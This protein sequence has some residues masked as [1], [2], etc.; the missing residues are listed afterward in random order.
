MSTLLFIQDWYDIF[1]V[2]VQ[3]S[4]IM[5]FISCIDVGKIL[6]SNNEAGVHTPITSSQGLYDYIYWPSV[7]KYWCVYY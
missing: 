2:T 3:H 4:N 1:L 6:S 5:F 7:Q